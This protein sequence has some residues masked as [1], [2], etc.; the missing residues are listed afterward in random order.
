MCL[1]K[2]SAERDALNKFI[3][4]NG[5]DTR[6]PWPPAHVQPFH[7]KKLGNIN[8][9]NSDNLYGRVLSLPIGNA[10]DESQVN[11]VV[12]KVKLFYKQN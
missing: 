7:K 2:N 11:Q 6:I 4:E 9:P 8:C 3:N 1:A 12:E 10:I 5:V